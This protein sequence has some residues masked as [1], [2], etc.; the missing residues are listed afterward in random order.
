M[1]HQHQGRGVVDGIERRQPQNKMPSQDAPYTPCHS[2]ITPAGLVDFNIQC[3]TSG[4]W[5]IWEQAAAPS[6]P[7][8]S[9]PW[10]VGG[11]SGGKCPPAW[12]YSA[13]GPAPS[14][15]SNCFSRCKQAI[16]VT[17]SGSR[18]PGFKVAL[19][20]ARPAPAAGGMALIRPA[21]GGASV[22]A[23]AAGAAGEPSRHRRCRRQAR[24]QAPSSKAV[25][26]SAGCSRSSPWRQADW[27]AACCFGC[28]AGR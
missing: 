9:D 20:G 18:A 13:L 27:Q 1:Q 2:V 14:H 15:H 5:G 4:S 25:C 8:P 11:G 21:A 10:G 3:V 22:G 7:G 26:H 17:R 23:R 12:G 16:Q 19:A 28:R 24:C 6:P